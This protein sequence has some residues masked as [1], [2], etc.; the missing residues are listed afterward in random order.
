[1]SACVLFNFLHVAH[2]SHLTP[3]PSLSSNQT[4]PNTPPPFSDVWAILTDY[5]RLAVHVPNLVQ[6]KVTGPSAAARSNPS[7][8]QVSF[9]CFVTFNV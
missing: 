9:D 2:F 5:N 6:S 4:N 1:M 8:S 7:A 3:L